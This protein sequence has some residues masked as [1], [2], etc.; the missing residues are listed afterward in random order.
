MHADPSGAKTYAE[1]DTQARRYIKTGPLTAKARLNWH[2]TVY[3]TLVYQKVRSFEAFRG[4][5]PSYNSNVGY[6]NFEVCR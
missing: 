4:A 2:K 5:L 3:V 6:C 1:R